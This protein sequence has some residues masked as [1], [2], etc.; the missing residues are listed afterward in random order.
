[1]AFVLLVGFIGLAG[2]VLY[3]D[4]ADP[5]TLFSTIAM[6]LLGLGGVFVLLCL[7]AIIMGTADSCLLVSTMHFVSRYLPIPLQA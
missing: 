2:R 1:M 5:E 7:Y 6:D 4:I 3:L